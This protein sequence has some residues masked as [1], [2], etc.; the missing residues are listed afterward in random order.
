MLGVDRADGGLVVRVRQPRG[1]CERLA[2]LVR[3]ERL[4]IA[5]LETLDDSTEDVL[6]YLLR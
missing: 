2:V 3:E 4:E 1:F 5:R 6:G